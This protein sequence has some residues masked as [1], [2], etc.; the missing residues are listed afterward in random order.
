M[1]VVVRDQMDGSGH[2]IVR[3]NQRIVQNQI[4]P[5]DHVSAIAISAGNVIP[6]T[7]RSKAP[8]DWKG[9]MDLGV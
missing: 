8:A 1:Q 9:R 4:V 7:S 2:M 3:R 6:G 5:L